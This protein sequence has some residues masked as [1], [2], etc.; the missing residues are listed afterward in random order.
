MLPDI[1]GDQALVQ[2][3]V[4]QAPNI[5]NIARGF[6]FLF[7]FTTAEPRYVGHWKQTEPVQ[8][9]LGQIGRAS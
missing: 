1:R 5:E 8:V 6:R 7:G 2:T 3:K 9:I 4:D